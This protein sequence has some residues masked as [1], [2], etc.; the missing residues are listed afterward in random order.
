LQK[1]CA[2][3]QQHPQDFVSADFSSQHLAWTKSEL[4]QRTIEMPSVYAIGRKL[5]NKLNDS[6][7]RY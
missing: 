1:L 4:H 5:H 7:W 2:F 3:I 6:I